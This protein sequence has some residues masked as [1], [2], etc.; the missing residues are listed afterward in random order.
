MVS[1]RTC[2]SVTTQ[3]IRTGLPRLEA[4]VER[5]SGLECPVFVLG[6]LTISPPERQYLLENATSTVCASL[7]GPAL[8]RRLH[9]GPPLTS[10]VPGLLTSIVPVVPGQG[11]ARGAGA[12]VTRGIVTAMGAGA[13]TPQAFI[14]VWGGDT[15]PCSQAPLPAGWGSCAPQERPTLFIRPWEGLTH[16]K[17]SLGV[18]LKALRTANLIFFCKAKEGDS[19]GI[20]FPGHLGL[21]P[22]AGTG[23]GPWL[24]AQP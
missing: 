13:G 11:E 23:R 1:L 15:R 16:T 10:A 17:C 8:R 24:G 22:W 4:A 7:W 5:H 12:E 14:L 19:K 3:K 9:P 18:Q 6:V 2:C 20:S 21:A